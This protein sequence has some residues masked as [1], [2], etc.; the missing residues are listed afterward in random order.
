MSWFSSTYIYLFT[1]YV[2][3]IAFIALWNLSVLVITIAQSSPQLV[4]LCLRLV[5]SL[6]LRGAPPDGP[7]YLYHLLQDGDQL[8]KPP[9]LLT[10]L[11]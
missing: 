5:A 10:D 4:Q 8:L 3:C 2:Y 11:M 9:P 1:S 7:E 6:P